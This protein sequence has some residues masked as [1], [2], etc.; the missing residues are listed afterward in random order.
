MNICIHKTLK[1]S[2]KIE[3]SVTTLRDYKYF[4]ND[5]FVKES[6]LTYHLKAASGLLI[7]IRLYKH[8]CKSVHFEMKYFILIKY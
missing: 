7:I 1:K 2:Y 3:V 6:S 5:A 4:L 8:P